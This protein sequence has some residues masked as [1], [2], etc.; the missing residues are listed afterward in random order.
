MPYKLCLVLKTEVTE[1]EGRSHLQQNI[2][3]YRIKPKW[4]EP[5]LQWALRW[6]TLVVCVHSCDT[7]VCKWHCLTLSTDVSFV[8]EPETAQL[9]KAKTV[10]G[11]SLTAW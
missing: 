2:Q 6:E 11:Y 10:K 8:K 9:H 3:E 4:E 5:A 7:R 1:K